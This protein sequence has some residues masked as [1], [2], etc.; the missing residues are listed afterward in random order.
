MHLQARYF[1]FLTLG[2]LVTAL[3][4]PAPV[5][6]QLEEIVVTAR[7]R[8]E[9]I[10]NVPVA[11][12]AF[13]EQDVVE[14]YTETIAEISRYIPNAQF[15]DVQFNG[16]GLSGG[17]RGISFGEVEKTYENAI[18]FSVDGVFLA[19]ATGAA[20]DVFDIESIEVLRGPQGTLFGRNTIGGTINVRRTRPTGELDLSTSVRVGSYKQ[21]DW[22]AVLNLPKLG[23]SLSTKLFFFSNNGDLFTKSQTPGVG[24]DGQ[25]TIQFGAT[26]LWEP[27]ENFEATFTAEHLD[28]DSYFPPVVNLAKASA[29]GGGGILRRCD[30]V[31]QFGR[32]LR[33]SHLYSRTSFGLQV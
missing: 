7:R 19:T 26:F 20:I 25:D 2:V 30:D 16:A 33:Y 5:A 29:P 1:S 24:N 4:L 21:H 6:A 31:L 11:V 23:D 28:D 18:G 9:S 3:T 27:S 15:A 10:Q 12:T 17:I 22:M 32:S 14:T 13:D 8:A